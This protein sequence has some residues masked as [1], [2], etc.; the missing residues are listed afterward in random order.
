M[1]Y[2]VLREKM[3]PLEK[4]KRSWHIF[5]LSQE[6]LGAKKSSTHKSATY[7]KTLCIWLFWTLEEIYVTEVTMRIVQ[8][9]LEIY[10]TSKCWDG[11]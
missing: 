2:L 1:A 10:G 7:T 8:L 5:S 6:I 3:D 11:I 4:S 9:R